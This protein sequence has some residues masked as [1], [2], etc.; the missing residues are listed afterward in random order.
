ME[1]LPTVLPCTLQ[2]R[3]PNG[4][5]HL[6]HQEAEKIMKFRHPI[7]KPAIETNYILILHRG[8]SADSGV[9]TPNGKRLLLGLHSI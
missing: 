6:L 7:P 1:M 3:N 9:F 5:N 8:A 4:P 2:R